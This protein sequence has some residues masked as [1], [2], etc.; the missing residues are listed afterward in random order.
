MTYGLGFGNVF[1][2]E[3]LKQNHWTQR[4]FKMNNAVLVHANAADVIL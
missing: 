3:V 4:N 1:K 2:Q